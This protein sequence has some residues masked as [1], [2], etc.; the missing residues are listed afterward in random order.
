MRRLFILILFIN[1]FFAQKLSVAQVYLDS[2]QSIE[3]RVA[4]LLGRMTLEEKVGQMAQAE[5]Q[6]FS[7][8]TDIK[9]YFI[10]SMLS[11]GGSSPTPNT[12]E[13][14]ANMYDSF[15]QQAL[16]TRL[17]IPL[18]YG[19][20]A[21]HGHNNV[22]NA[23]IFPHNIGLGCTN[24]LE[25]VKEAARITAL[26]VMGT[27]INWTFS[28]C[29]AVIRD[30]R[31]GRTY[32]G[33]GESTSLVSS[34][35]VATIKGLQGETFSGKQSILACAKHY[36]G[37]GGTTNGDDQG[38]TEIDEAT[39]RSLFLPPYIEAINAG[40]G[41]IMASYSSWN[42]VKLHGHKYLLTDV[43]KTE[44]GFDGFVVSDYAGIDQLPGDYAAKVEA[45]I[46]AGIDMVML[47]N[48]YKEFTQTLINLVS[49][50]RVTIERI[51][52]AVARILRIKFR[53]G[54]FEHPY[55]DR[56]YTSKIGSPEHRMV[57][58]ECVRQSCVL[59]K[60]KDDVLPLLKDGMKIHVAGKNANNLG[61]QCGGWSIT[62]QGSSGNITSGTTILKAIQNAATTSTV[63]YS[64]DGTGVE[65]ADIAIAVIGETPYAEGQGDRDDLNFTKEDIETVRRLKETGIPVVVV[66]ISGRPMIINTI[67]HFS[68][69]I[70]AAW[71]PGTEGDGV[72]D[73]LFGDYQP[74]GRLSNSWPADM[75]SVPINAGDDDYDPLFD[76]GHGILTLNNSPVGS[77]PY[78]YSAMVTSDGKHLELAF[79]KAM[80]DPSTHKGSFFIKTN[81]WQQNPIEV[82]HKENDPSVIVLSLGTP[83]KKGDEVFI[84]YY[85]V[86]FESSDGGSLKSIINYEAYNLMNDN[87]LFSLPCKIEAEEYYSMSGV[88]TENTTDIL[89]GLN[90]GWI[91]AND[92]MKYLIDVPYDG[93]Y[94]FDFRIAALSQTGEFTLSIPDTILTTVSVPITGGWQ[95]WQTISATVT[96]NKGQ[97]LLNLGVKKGGFNLN[98]IEVELKEVFA[99]DTTSQLWPV[100][101]LKQN[102]PNPF[103][104]ETIIEYTVEKKSNVRI[105]IYDMIGQEQAVLLDEVI[106]PG[107][108]NIRINRHELGLR[109]GTYIYKMEIGDYK[110]V[111]K[112]IVK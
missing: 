58:R 96:L 100:N 24:N 94:Q 91:D 3:V 41:S 61:H 6:A 55:T 18:I 21:V 36:I 80:K 101:S 71:L 7:D 54:L 103:G 37:D 38:N 19:V 11:G 59:L 102:Y 105:A 13:S 88:Q 52:D 46:N 83:I 70:I 89:G 40:V 93:M 1:T 30:E 79:N 67:Q 17:K 14:W 63:T 60:L 78:P 75:A 81:Y 65:D 90:V 47:P 53:A 48:N 39:L 108:Y 31:W 87:D 64:I 109:N 97:K 23:V 33:F 15:Q 34:M 27:G 2:T 49:Q 42:G 106:K 92:W 25:L 69:A 77:S 43:L 35:G 111:R 26:E 28:P 66:I 51:D 29:I 104:S 110:E 73:I 50:N 68:D 16:A 107:S 74:T 98:W 8:I 95:N 56:T 22:K 85:G 99:I 12:G 72:A 57:A 84:S 5:R 10:G 86:D 32:E 20:D 62:W 112:M 4:D 76:L 82:A 45:S 44:L 9:T